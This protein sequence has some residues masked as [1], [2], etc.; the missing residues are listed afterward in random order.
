MAAVRAAGKGEPCSALNARFRFIVAWSVSRAAEVSAI[1]CFNRRF[2]ELKSGTRIIPPITANPITNSAPMANPLIPGV[3]GWFHRLS[4]RE[5]WLW[6]SLLISSLH[7][8]LVSYL[9]Q[10]KVPTPMQ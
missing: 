2:C 3:E 7:R 10:V 9:Q 1:C 6:V 8:V 5:F 4:L